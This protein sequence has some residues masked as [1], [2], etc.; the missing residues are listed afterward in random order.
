MPAG[1]SRTW[2]IQLTGDRQAATSALV[3]SFLRFPRLQA[4]DRVFHISTCI[5]SPAYGASGRTGAFSPGHSCVQCRLDSPLESEAELIQIVGAKGAI[6]SLDD[7]RPELA[8]AMIFAVGDTAPTKS[9]T[10]LRRLAEARQQ[11]L[12]PAGFPVFIVL[13]H[14]GFATE[15]PSDTFAFQ[16]RLL[17]ELDLVRDPSGRFIDLRIGRL[18]A[19]S[20]GSGDDIAAL[21]SQCLAAALDY[22]KR[23]LRAERRLRWTSA[24]ATTALIMM[25]FGLVVLSFRSEPTA[26]TVE[27]NA[28]RALA[29]N[30]PAWLHEPY[31]P[32]AQRL[33]KVENNQDFETLS[34]PDRAF[35][36]EALHELRDYQ[37]YR[38]RLLDMDLN[39]PRSKEELIAV[40]AELTSGRLAVPAAYREQWR[41]TN[42]YDYHQV[43]LKDLAALQRAINKAVAWYADRT[44]E[45]NRLYAFP[46]G[47]PK[48][49]NE[50]V[51]W[52]GRSQAALTTKLPY[53]PGDPVLGAI[54]LT[55][56]AV[57][58]S[59]DVS[60]AHR[61]W[62]LDSDRLD[63]LRALILVLGLGGPLPNG[64]SAPLDIGSNFRAAEA[65]RRLEDLRRLAPD[66]EKGPLPEV[67][68]AIIGDIRRSLAEDYRN[69]IQ[70]GQTV[71][72]QHFVEL[73]GGE[74][75]WRGWQK[76]L[77]YL[78][79]PEDLEAWRTLTRIVQRLR[80]EP[81]AD[82]ISVLATF[83]KRDHFDLNPQEAELRLPVSASAA[84]VPN[85]SLVIDLDGPNI[86]WIFT[87]SGE[88][89]PDN[90]AGTLRYRFRRAQ[91]NSARF[92]PGDR[93]RASLPVRWS[94]KPGNLSLVWDRPGNS[95]WAFDALARPPRWLASNDST[96]E[97]G[98]VSSCRLI[99]LPAASWPS[100]PD[101]LPPMASQGSS[102]AGHLP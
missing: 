77:P 4:G 18:E 3:E 39:R 102:R 96:G 35:I 87:L 74:N 65:G 60:Q 15:R 30:R 83:F 78:S 51:V 67:P 101:L 84:V 40:G 63:R 99:M 45:L 11:A 49:P 79:R 97:N 82:P 1:Q 89:E 5:P 52:L 71:I 62:T 23:M 53:S 14:P 90:A 54:M 80:G 2:R 75:S 31:E 25:L 6:D 9:I 19:G 21:V 13:T 47:R 32:K 70:A 38:A 55:Y 41:G 56:V 29:T 69:L 10:L 58:Q 68:E 93:I 76:L 94:N 64:N 22:G 91:A 92:V 16:K 33:L 66:L 12:E 37:E 20:P 34:P 48:T 17:E 98:P 95:T 81:P 85:G 72:Q 42:A 100:L 57:I 27:L 46:S 36:R 44:T 59:P 24:G 7:E 86:Q 50:W 28:L 43:L 73:N 61:Q 8:V 26:I 88:P